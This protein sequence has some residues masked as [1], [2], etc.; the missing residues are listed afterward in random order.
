MFLEI[1]TIAWWLEYGF[2]CE[3][4][5]HASYWK[6]NH[7]NFFNRSLMLFLVFCDFLSL[8]FFVINIMVMVVISSPLMLAALKWH[9]A[10]T[11]LI[12]SII[13]EFCIFQQYS[14]SGTNVLTLYVPIQENGQTNSNDSSQFTDKLFECVWPFFR[15]AT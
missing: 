10:Y 11:V 3:A 15:I 9:T 14:W 1:T 6:V 2:V 7:L 12:I 5:L 4:R 8:S 13:T